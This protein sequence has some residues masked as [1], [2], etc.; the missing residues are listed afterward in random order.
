M[1]RISLQY[2]ALSCIIEGERGVTMTKQEYYTVAE[3]AVQLRVS[4][5]TV[6]RL[7]R[8]EKLQGEKVGK[9]WRI[10]DSA[11]QEYLKTSKKKG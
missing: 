8:A 5:D 1:Q 6:M 10:S 7:L 2:T 11:L 3:V 9:Q 4:A